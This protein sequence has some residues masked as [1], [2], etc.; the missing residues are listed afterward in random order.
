MRNIVRKVVGRW[1][2]RTLA[3][4]WEEW[5]HLVSHSK[6]LARVLAR[7]MNQCV[8]AALDTWYGHAQEQRKMR[9]V[10]RRMI[11]RMKNAACSRA[12]QR[13]SERCA[14][15]GR[16]RSGMER[17]LKHWC[18]T[19]KAAAMA[20][21]KGLVVEVVSMRNI[22]RKVVGRWLHR[23]LR[24]WF[25]AFCSA[26]QMRR[27]ALL[28]SGRHSIVSLSLAVGSFNSSG[29]RPFRRL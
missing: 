13:W 19:H 12:I 27:D 8:A 15:A 6:A 9:D 24:R 21:W 23:V 28:V 11:L 1:L 16:L 3:Q 22:V 2:S 29:E 26:V 7:M 10:S 17:V 18:N 14:E 25:D 5:R 20:R 4:A